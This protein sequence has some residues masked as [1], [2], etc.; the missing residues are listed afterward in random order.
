MKLDSLNPCIKT[1]TKHFHIA[2]YKS[3]QQCWEVT[4]YITALK[5]NSEVLYLS[6]QFAVTFNSYNTTT[7]QKYQSL[8]KI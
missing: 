6:I 3:S 7:I 1:M 5:Y 8:Y 4:K 2:L